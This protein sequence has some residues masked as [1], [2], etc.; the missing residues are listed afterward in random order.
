MV[1]VLKRKGG[2]KMKDKRY[3]TKCSK[4]SEEFPR[5]PNESITCPKCRQ[6]VVVGGWAGDIEI[7]SSEK[8]GASRTALREM[9]AEGGRGNLCIVEIITGN[10]PACKKAIGGK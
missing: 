9:I 10:C 7:C 2:K 8:C 1:S 5:K 4:C 6:S 3:P